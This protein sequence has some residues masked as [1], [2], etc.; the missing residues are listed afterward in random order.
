MK[1]T[2]CG[3]GLAGG[4]WTWEEDKKKKRKEVQVVGSGTVKQSKEDVLLGQD[5]DFTSW[6]ERGFPH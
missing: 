2:W 6:K 5:S 1:G 4:R 3:G